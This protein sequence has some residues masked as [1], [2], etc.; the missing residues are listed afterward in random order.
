MVNDRGTLKMTRFLL[1]ISLLFLVSS[2][3]FAQS[4]DKQALNH[5]LENCIDALVT[6]GFSGSVLVALNDSIVLNDGFGFTSAAKKYKVTPTTLFNIASIT[7]T[8]TAL[9]ILKLEENGRLQ[10]TD[11]LGKYFKV[12]PPDKKTITIHELLTHTSGLQQHYVDMGVSSR[13]AAVKNILD[14]TLKFV[15][16]SD[17]QYSNENYELL[18]A[19]IE[20]ASGKSYE[21][22]TEDEILVPAKTTNTHFWGEIDDLDAQKVAQ[23]VKD[24]SKDA[25]KRN[26]DFLGSG[27]IY[28]TSPDLFKLYLAVKSN[29]IINPESTN[30][31][32]QSYRKLSSSSVGYGWFIDETKWDTKEYWTRGTEDFGHNSVLRW[33]PEDNVVIIVCSNAGEIL[34][35]TTAD[36][37]T[38]AN[39]IVSDNLMQILFSRWLRE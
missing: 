9:G 37:T 6:K 7:K 33:F 20:V 8:F 34:G 5:K 24:L 39:R 36:K 21:R 26:W 28:S 15:P 11:S 14:D 18:A 17:F 35:G 2:Q 23:K 13:E 29:K 19:I 22:F 12:V 3:T 1:H 10:L 32:F 30:R 27:G 38:T 16:G 4:A 31:M 25:R